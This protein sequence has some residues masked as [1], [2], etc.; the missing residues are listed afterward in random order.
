[1]N[2]YYFYIFEVIAL[3]PPLVRPDTGGCAGAPTRPP[4][5][6]RLAATLKFNEP[7]IQRTDNNFVTSRLLTL[8]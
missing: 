8:T 1:M 7:T 4:R 5:H 2:E 3:W 6:A